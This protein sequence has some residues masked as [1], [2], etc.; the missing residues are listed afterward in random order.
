MMLKLSLLRIL[1]IFETLIIFKTIYQFIFSYLQIY[2][3]TMKFEEL[4]SNIHIK[5]VDKQNNMNL[6]MCWLYI[7]SFYYKFNPNII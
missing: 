2:I 6:Y 5:I 7:L 3:L 4:I 1:R